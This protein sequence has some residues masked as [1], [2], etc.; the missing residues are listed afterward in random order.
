MTQSQRSALFWVFLTLFVGIVVV[1]LLVALRVG[2]FSDATPAF[3]DLAVA[4]VVGGLVGAVL[5]TYRVAFSGGRDLFITL[6][7]EGTP[8]QNIDLVPQGDYE[9][10]DQKKARVGRTGHLLAQFG[11]GGWSCRLPDHVGRDD[12]V[13]S[14]FHDR[15][16]QRWEV[17]YFSPLFNEQ[18][19]V[20]RQ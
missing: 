9:I 8:G 12:S 14:V 19:V 15:S 11:Q 3:Q 17:R 20:R 5:T 7:F 16:G 1:S 13:R 6:D 10:W 18:P 4:T 2:P